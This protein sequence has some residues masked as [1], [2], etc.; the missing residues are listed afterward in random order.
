MEQTREQQI[1]HAREQVQWYETEMHAAHEMMEKG[2]YANGWRE[3]KKKLEQ[4][5]AQ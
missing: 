3:W 4:L 1:A 2:K 5:E